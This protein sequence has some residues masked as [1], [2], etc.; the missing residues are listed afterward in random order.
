V[1]EIRV[2]SYKDDSVDSV[3]DPGVVMDSSADSTKLQPPEQ[4]HT[5][6]QPANTPGSTEHTQIAPVSLS[7]T[8]LALQRW[9][10]G[11]VV[12]DYE[13]L[14]RIGE[15]ALGVVYLAKQISLNRHVALKVTNASR[16]GTSE[17]LALA[18]LEHE[19]IVKVYASFVDTATEK[20]CLSLQY[21]PGTNLAA[22]IALLHKAPPH[23]G[24][25]IL[26]VIDS[27]AKRD[28]RFDPTALPDRDML[29]KLDFHSA[30][31]RLGEQLCS[32]L[33]FAHSRDILHCDIKPGNILLTHYGRPMLVDFNISVSCAAEGVQCPV[34]GTPKYMSP[35]QMAA[36]RNEPHT[37]ID[38]R[39]DQ[40]S[41]G[42]VLY[43]LATG[44]RFSPGTP[45]QF[46]QL[47]SELRT[48]LRRALQAATSERYETATEFGHALA[49]AR[50]ILTTRKQ[51]PKP[52]RI[53]RWSIQRPITMLLVLALI[54]H[55]LATALNIAYNKVEIRL[56]EK[57]HTV[58]T[59]MI[60]IYNLS[61]YSV[62]LGVAAS[63]LTRFHRKRLA[64]QNGE[65]T[66]EQLD[67]TRREAVRLTHRGVMFALLGWAPG[68]I[69]FPLVIHLFASH[70]GW[71]SYIHFF[72]SFT[73]SG[74]I[75]MVYSYFGIQYVIL[76]SMYPQL[77]NPNG[78]SIS[79]TQAELYE[80]TRCL[81]FFLILATLI[82]LTGAVLL[83][84]L[85]DNEVTL[86]FRFLVTSLIVL[87]M[88]GITGLLRVMDHL[89][90]LATPW[91]TAN[92]E[93]SSRSN[94]WSAVW[95]KS[96]L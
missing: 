5:L 76:R 22:V 2:S 52:S 78:F 3:P 25:D 60:P 84:C 33:T 29:A 38:H 9:Q 48:V 79:N 49:G 69:L 64:A 74:L 53:G 21:V 4:I 39:T 10:I 61:I 24:Q 30:V 51:L 47:P 28:G 7:A 44:V 56:D 86:G 70:P 17:G 57:Q 55:I 62:C 18:G 23:T 36:F 63:I 15:G 92:D 43:E 11:Q 80:G 81:G 50:A 45:G 35:E 93:V 19:H 96:Q 68:A 71:N 88:L 83:I 34:G 90:A 16:A 73:L 14:A 20:H 59:R 1:F 46:D 75:G 85:I 95:R 27:V 91:M 32:A 8:I 82:P 89:A 67:Q 58:F 54:P 31:C 37:N 72:I 65:L 13:L 94:S 12:D 42:L 66:S 40:Y 6:T 41:L 87:G 26:N 77:V